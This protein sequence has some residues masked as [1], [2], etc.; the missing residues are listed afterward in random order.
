M[1]SPRHGLDGNIVAGKLPS[2]QG[3]EDI[4]IVDSSI[5]GSCCQISSVAVAVTAEG[6]K[7]LGWWVGH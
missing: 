6:A 3:M 1:A 7:E 4:Y 5:L 2:K